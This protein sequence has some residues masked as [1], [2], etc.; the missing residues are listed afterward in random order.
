VP[1]YFQSCVSRT[2]LTK[3]LSVELDV[4]TDKVLD[5]EEEIN[6]YQ[7][8]CR[9]PSTFN[10][11]ASIFW[12]TEGGLIRDILSESVMCSLSQM[13]AFTAFWYFFTCVTYGTNVPAGL[14]LPGMIIGCGLGEI[15]SKLCLNMGIFDDEHYKIYRVTYIILAMGAMLASYTRMTYSL[16]II[17]METSQAI[18]IFLPITVTIAVAVFTGQFFTRGLYDRAVRAKQMPI[19]KKEVPGVNAKIRAEEIMSA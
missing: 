8:W 16:A 7:A 18:N 9:D 1:Y 6:V 15:Y 14:F 5:S 11:I 17:V 10:P 12:Q 3:E 2:I 13:I 4:S 19:L